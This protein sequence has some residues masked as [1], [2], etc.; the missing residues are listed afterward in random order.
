MICS[1]DKNPESWIVNLWIISEAGQ[2]TLDE[3]SLQINSHI[4]GLGYTSI[5]ALYIC[6][7]TRNNQILS[8]QGTTRCREFLAERVVDCW[9]RGHQLGSWHHISLNILGKNLIDQQK[10]SQFWAVIKKFVN[11]EVKILDLIGWADHQIRL[12]H[13]SLLNLKWILGFSYQH[14]VST[15]LTKIGWCK[16]WVHF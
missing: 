5:C 6:I 8:E 16:N 7:K 9:T 13:W 10:N 11:S 15:E 4:T 3:T 12:Q 14:F 1:S 2:V